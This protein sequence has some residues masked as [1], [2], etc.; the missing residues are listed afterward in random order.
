MF[1]FKKKLTEVE[2]LDQIRQRV[3]QKLSIYNRN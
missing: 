3:K 2:K 1:T